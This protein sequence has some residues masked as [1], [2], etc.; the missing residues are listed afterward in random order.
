MNNA[1]L[2]AQTLNQNLE[3][4][5]PITI[6]GAGALLLDPAFSPRLSH[7]KTNDIDIIIP[8]HLEIQNNF[9]SQ[10]WK[11]VEKTNEQLREKHLYITHIF[12]ESLIILTQD[13]R[14]HTVPLAIPEF[15]K[16]QIERPGILDIII[17]KTCR[18]DRRD[19]EDIRI[20]LELN[21]IPASVI[22]AAAKTAHVPEALQEIFPIALHK[23][24]NL[25]HSMENQ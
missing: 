13:W 18:A 3:R 15:D 17:S 12:P 20:M 6:F 1:Y 5:T 9:D 2:L 8:S 16:L 19:L 24:L 23:V 4:L 11:A 7:R 22:E 21:P 14:K 10:F 25:V